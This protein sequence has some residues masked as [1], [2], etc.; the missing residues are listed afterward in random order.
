MAVKNTHQFFY[1]HSK[2]LNSMKCQEI[3]MG[4]SIQTIQC[5]TS[6]GHTLNANAHLWQ[7]KASF[8]QGTQS[9]NMHSMCYE[10]L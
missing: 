10:N 6:A 2:Y 4:P 5:S 8:S 3:S 9:V 7:G 1:Y